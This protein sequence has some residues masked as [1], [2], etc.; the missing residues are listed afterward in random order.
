MPQIDITRN[1]KHNGHVLQP[2][3]LPAAVVSAAAAAAAGEVDA[4]HGDNT[5]LR[6]R[7]EELEQKL[8]AATQEAEERWT[9]R[10]AEYETLLDE[11]SEVIR[12]L[13]QKMA[14]LREQLSTGG[15][16]A[17]AKVQAADADDLMQIRSELEEQRRQLAEDE[18]S[19][20]SQLRQMEM[21]LARDRAELARQRAEVQRLH[22]EMKHD[23]ETA[24][25]D[26]GLR[27]RL[28]ALQ[29]RGA[30]ATPPARP[31]VSQD[32]PLPPA[33]EPKDGSAAKG[34][35]GIFRRLFGTGQ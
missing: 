31:S 35:T 19:M 15:Q 27:E 1:A 12:S 32:T 13:H 6:A 11:K 21:A 5:A 7:V 3:S 10:Q 34:G 25:R 9:Q 18:E 14:E 29:R 30:P 33:P 17:N 24:A 16:A 23:M 22:N 4:L 20:M 26:G 2:N 28:N 8:A